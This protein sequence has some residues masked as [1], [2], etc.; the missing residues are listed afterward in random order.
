MEAMRVSNCEGNLLDETVLCFGLESFCNGIRLVR[1]RG[2]G[3]QCAAYLA[4]P[5]DFEP[6]SY[7]AAARKKP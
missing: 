7:S 6:A 3:T 4:S 2:C 5:Q 1:A